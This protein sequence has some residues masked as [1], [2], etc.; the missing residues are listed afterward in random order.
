MLALG[1]SA[2][3]TALAGG[4]GPAAAG[5]APASAAATVAAAARTRNI[6]VAA[7]V[8]VDL[9][10]PALRA[11]LLFP[12]PRQ[13]LATP[14]YFKGGLHGDV[15]FVGEHYG[16]AMWSN[17][18]V[19]DVPRPGLRLGDLDVQGRDAA[20]G[21]LAVA[22]SRQG[23][24]KV[25]DIMGAD[26]ALADAGTPF[27][28]GIDSYTLAIL[29]VPSDTAPWMLQFGGHHLALNLTLMG[30]HAVLA[31]VLTGAQP[32]VYTRNGRT[33]RALASENDK[34][35][36][37]LATFDADQRRRAVIDGPVDTLELGPGRDGAT[38][39]LQGVSASAMNDGQ[40]AML[41]D[42]VSDWAGIVNAD[43]AAPRLAEIAAGLP[44]TWFAWKGPDTHEPNRNGASYFRVQGPTI[45]VEFAPQWPGGD[46]TQHVHTIYRDFP[47]AYGRA[48]VPGLDGGSRKI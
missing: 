1:A 47:D 31:P 25:Q 16:D 33:V 21:L 38:I 24:A 44:E 34:G 40:R 13:R 19:S 27:A 14:A 45:Y 26:Q 46:L 28:C 30:E 20:L 6:A 2:S 11:R 10:E 22:L 36:A 48:F 3:F 32:A 4:I 12:F 42:L 37:L 5:V 9:L 15:T 18:P 35:F 29:G 23:Y 39:P 41:L 43:H 8:L 17:F 7:A